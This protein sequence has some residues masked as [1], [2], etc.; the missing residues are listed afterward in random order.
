MR[1]RPL[2]GNGC[3]AACAFA[4]LGHRAAL[5]ALL[6]LW[7]ALPV[8]ATPVP[9]P[10]ASVAGDAETVFAAARSSLLQIRTLVGEG[11]RQASIG[12]GFLVSAD[13]LAITNYHVVA[14]YALDPSAYRLEYLRADGSSG[15]LALLAFD[16]TA[17]LAVVRLPGDGH[18][19]LEFDPR[20]VA[21]EVAKGE[22]LFAIGNPLDLGFTI[23]EGNH[24][25]RVD[26]SYIDRVHFSGALNPGMSGGPTLTARQQVAGV[27]VAKLL[28][29]DLVSFLV[30]AR[31]AAALLERAR[32]QPPLELAAVRDEIAR[33]LDA[34][35]QT[36]FAALAESEWRSPTF[37]PYVAP[38]PAAPWFSCWASTNAD[39]RPRPRVLENASQCTMQSEIFIDDETSTGLVQISHHWLRARELNPPQFAAFLT[40][41]S[42]ATV[43]RGTKATTR[44][45]CVDGFI[46]TVAG[47][48]EL[49]TV[50]CASAYTEFAGLYDVEVFAL[51]RD[52]A[53]E[54]LLSRLVVRGASYAN[55][56]SLAERFVKGL[57][58]TPR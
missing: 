29:G 7:L 36:L 42:G 52:D 40:Q 58:W 46:A 9:G 4:A 33:Q 50:F 48:P 24:N 41:R 11:G 53:R 34:W 13:G 3:F 54:S 51:T 14:Q 47:G 2:R 22:R 37:G 55:A 12:S 57:A 30:P 5:L 1:F 31:Y 16:V 18:P 10:A 39:E 56:L 15:A 19:F 26:K 43:N 20:A 38:E 6:T 8:A 17:D 44:G 28:A 45:R 27:N 32:T 21:D 23:V 49:K 25:G 35:Q